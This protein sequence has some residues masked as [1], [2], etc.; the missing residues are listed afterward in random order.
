MKSRCAAFV[1]PAQFLIFFL[2]FFFILMMYSY[3][4]LLQAGQMGT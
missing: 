4:L 1:F 3:K 2:D